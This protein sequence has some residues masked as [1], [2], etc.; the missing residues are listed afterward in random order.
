MTW[1]NDYGGS[2]RVYSEMKPYRIH[3]FDHGGN[4]RYSADFM[5]EHD[6]HAKAHA[7]TVWG[8]SGIGAKYEVWQDDRLVHSGKLP[9]G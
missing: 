9:R 7:D 4:A 5:A 6:D 2:G 8:G 3:V 1:R